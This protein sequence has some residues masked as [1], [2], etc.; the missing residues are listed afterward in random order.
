[1][2]RNLFK[3]V[4]TAPQS[5]A[6]FRNQI[7]SNQSLFPLQ[8]WRPCQDC[9]DSASPTSPPPCPSLNPGSAS[10][11]C[12]VTLPISQGQRDRALCAYTT[13]IPQDCYFCLWIYIVPPAIFRKCLSN[14]QERQG[15]EVNWDLSIINHLSD[16]KLDDVL[17]DLIKNNFIEILECNVMCKHEFPCNLHDHLM[18]VKSDVGMFSIRRFFFNLLLFPLLFPL[19]RLREKG[20]IML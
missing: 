4:K 8:K 14:G 2:T 18:K 19:L 5:S 15:L 9:R 16:I 6:T 20:V 11:Y 7:P 10:T 12:G 17:Q 1:M 3:T 13:V